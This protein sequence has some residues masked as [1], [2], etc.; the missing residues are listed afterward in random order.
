[1]GGTDML[2][3]VYRLGIWTLFTCFALST[4]AMADVYRWTSDD[5]SVAFSNL[6]HRVPRELRSTL[7][8]VPS[9]L[10]SAYLTAAPEGDSSGDSELVVP[11]QQMGSLIEVSVRLNEQVTAPF[12]LDT[13]ASS[14]VIPSSVAA[15]LDLEP[16]STSKTTYARTAN[17]RVP[18][19]VTKLASVELR[20]A[21]VK[22]VDC[23]ISDQLEVGLLGAS[24]LR[25]FKYTV[26]S[27]SQTL[28][29]E[30]LASAGGTASLRLDR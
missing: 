3:F 17:G 27:A 1:M 7:V 10:E 15:A 13:A 24:F 23:L 16:R 19:S 9:D 29:F 5:G 20:G 18:M 30:P 26:D 21:S 28:V 22:D 25:H 12:Y 11:F 6:R 14:V 2:R 4:T 8:L